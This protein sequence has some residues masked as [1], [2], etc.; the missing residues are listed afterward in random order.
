MSRN[1]FEVLRAWWESTQR[2]SGPRPSLRSRRR[3][4][5]H[6]ALIRRRA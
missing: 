1:W 3:A 5:A 2:H 4:L 6:A